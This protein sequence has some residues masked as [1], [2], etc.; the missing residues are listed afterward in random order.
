MLWIKTKNRLPPQ[1]KKVLCFTDGDCHVAQRFGKYWF[2]IPFTDSKFARIDP[3][4]F[5]CDIVMPEPYEGRMRILIDKGL[6]DI[7]TLQKKH[8][9]AY[10]QFVNLLLSQFRKDRW[11]HRNG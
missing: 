1:G 5:W 7:D 4:Q 2:P 11:K 9:A 8:K 3:P 6:Y 10:R